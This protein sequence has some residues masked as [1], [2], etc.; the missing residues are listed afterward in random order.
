MTTPQSL[1][2]R[3]L[4]G[5]LSVLL[6][7]TSLLVAQNTTQPPVEPT[8]PPSPVAGIR[9]KIS[10]GD[11]LSAE[12][13]L[14]V[15]RATNGEDGQWLRGLSWLAR[16]ALLVGDTAKAELYTAQVRENC[17][18]R[19]ARG[20]ELDKDPDIEIAYGAAVEVKAQ[21]LEL[22]RGPDH[23]AEYIQSELA[24]VKSPVSLVSRLYKRLNVLTLAD[25]PAPELEIEDFIGAVPPTLSALKGRPVILFIWAEWCGDCKAQ[26]AGLANVMTR[27]RDSLQLVALTR[28]YEEEQDRSREKGKIDSVWT[29]VYSGLGRVP[30]VISTASMER[31]G[32]SST[33]TLVFIDR[34]G[35]VRRYTPTRLTEAELDRTLAR[36][37]Q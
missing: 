14:E 36:L 15:H 13:I 4:A 29:A 8:P 10:A 17:A 30:L 35:I 24:L 25:K 31:Y 32:G 20:A 21:L 26:A 23:A 1:R 27:Y 16:G 22:A 19:M 37:L 7:P 9:N 34:S 3:L 33:P 11:L 6:T 2:L 18:A 5:L 28:Y 12:S